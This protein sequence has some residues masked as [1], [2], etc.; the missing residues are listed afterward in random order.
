MPKRNL[1]VFLFV[2]ASLPI[3][4]YFITTS[5]L[6]PFFYCLREIRPSPCVIA[7]SYFQLAEY[8]AC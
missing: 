8:N 5:N 6:E 7:F 2:E 4:D 1:N 3:R